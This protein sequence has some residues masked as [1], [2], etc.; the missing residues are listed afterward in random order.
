MRV[1]LFR[2]FTYYLLNHTK[3]CFLTTVA[4]Y[5]VLAFFMDSSN[6]KNLP[7]STVWRQ[8]DGASGTITRE[9]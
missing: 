5:G 7:V 3:S 2:T 1:F 9:K 8:F 4:W 6:K